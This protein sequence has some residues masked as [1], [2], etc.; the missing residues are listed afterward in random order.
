MK[1]TSLFLIVAA[2]ATNLAVVTL[3]EPRRV[4]SAEELASNDIVFVQ[5]ASRQFH[6]ATCH[7]LSGAGTASPKRMTRKDAE[8]AGYHPCDE[9]SLK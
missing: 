4:P 7:V 3:I 2:I 5:P 8:R 9:C 1:Y 6:T